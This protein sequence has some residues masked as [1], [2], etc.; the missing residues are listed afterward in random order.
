MWR[1]DGSTGGAD[2]RSSGSATRSDRIPS[3]V[4]AP[5]NGSGSAGTSGSGVGRI[6]GPSGTGGGTSESSWWLI[7]SD[8]REAASFAIG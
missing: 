7:A 3:L 4:G 2:S 1:H 5:L 6:T 8:I